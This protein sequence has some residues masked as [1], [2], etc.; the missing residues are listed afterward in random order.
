MKGPGFVHCN[1]VF[2]MIYDCLSLQ[3]STIADSID[4][5]FPVKGGFYALRGT[6]DS[7]SWIFWNAV[8]G[9]LSCIN[10]T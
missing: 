6:I 3:L 10:K 7:V 9:A 2:L 1:F 8:K 4:H 5:V